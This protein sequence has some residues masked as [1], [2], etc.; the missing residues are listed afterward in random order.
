[1]SAIIIFM[2]GVVNQP[3]RPGGGA[4]FTGTKDQMYMIFGILGFVLLFGF[5]SLIA[6]LWQLVFGRRN[7]MLIYLI[8]GLG[9]IFLIGGSIFRAVVGD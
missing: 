6:G 9:A 4:R 3:A 8:L 2:L 1:M 7:M 5:T